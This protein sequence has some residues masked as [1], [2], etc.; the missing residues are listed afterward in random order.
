MRLLISLGERIYQA[1][2]RRRIPLVEFS[3]R[4]GVS[5]ETVYRIEQ[6]DPSVSMGTVARALAV[7]G[8]DLDL[9]LVAQED[10]VGRKL[11]DGAA[12]I[13]RRPKEPQL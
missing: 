9:N 6:G 11:Q 10:P 4:I 5:R 13:R 12:T 1:R 7:L 3:Q 8:L 2:L